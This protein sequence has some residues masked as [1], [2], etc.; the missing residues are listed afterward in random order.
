MLRFWLGEIVHASGHLST[1]ISSLPTTE[2]AMRAVETDDACDLSL[3]F[4]CGAVG[5][6]SLTSVAH[7]YRGLSWEVHGREGSLWIEEDGR[8][9]V[10]RR[11]SS[12]REDASVPDGLGPDPVLDGSQWARGFVLFARD[13]AQALR[14]GAT[15]SYAAT[16][17]DGL[18]TQRTLDAVRAASASASERN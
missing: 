11:G 2:G 4:A 5:S 8:L 13:I 7:A 15:V 9:F 12:E 14:D 17:E 10:A 1:S 6:V 18:A 3:R 16:F